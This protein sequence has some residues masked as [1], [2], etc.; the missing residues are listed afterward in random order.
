VPFSPGTG[1]VARPTPYWRATEPVVGLVGAG[2]EHV[3]E[4]D[5]ES[6]TGVAT[7]QATL[8]CL[9]LKSRVALTPLKGWGLTAC[10]LLILPSS[11]QRLPNN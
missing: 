5:F 6:Y 2:A 8:V 1:D 4:L 11:L 3:L 9:C 10:R 7:T